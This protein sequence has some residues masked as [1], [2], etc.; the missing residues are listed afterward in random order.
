MAATLSAPANPLL[1]PLSLFLA[2]L[3]LSIGWG[4]RG[5]FGHESGAWIPG[6]LAA[7]AVYLLS[8]RDDWQRRV[9]YCALFGGLGWGFGGSISY[10]YT[11]AFAGSGQWQTTWYGYFAV[12]LVGG[13]W[14]G[15]GGAG[16]ALPLCID[17]DRLTRLFVPICFVLV[18]MIVNH[19][20]Y[21]PLS[22]FLKTT[23]AVAPDGTWG[24]HKSPL[25]WLDSDWLAA[26]WA[27]GG[28]CLYDL[29]ERRFSG[30]L[31]L[32]LLAAAGSI[33]GYLLQLALNLTGLSPHIA[34]VLVVPQGDLTAV[35]PETHEPFDPNNLLTN[36]PQFFSDFPEHLGWEIGLLVGVTIYFYRFGKWKNDAKL[37]LYMALGWLL[38]FL[39]MPVL[40]TIP[41]QHFGGFRLTPPRGD[42]WAGVLGV[43]IATC[44]YAMRY[45]MAPVA[46]AAV[47]NFVLGGISF[48]SMHFVRQMLMIP[49]HPALNWQSGGTPAAWQHFQNANWHSV[50]EQLQGFGFGIVTAITMGFLWP[51][52]QPTTD[53]PRVR[54]WTEVF[55]IDFVVCFMTWVNLVKNVEQWTGKEHPVVPAVMKA[56]LIAGIE[57]N[58]VVWFNLAWCAM[59]CAFVG[60]SIMHL[61]RRLEIVPASWIGR[62][63]LI[64]VLLLWIMVIGNFE[65]L[66][67]NFTEARLMTEWV[68][69]LNASLATFLAIVLPRPGTAVAI[70]EPVDYGPLI[71]RV[72]VIGLGSAAL[73]MTLFAGVIATVYGPVQDKI[74]GSQLRFGE[75]ATWRIK[76]ILKNKEHR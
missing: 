17:R 11:L 67:P 76:P 25:Y 5:Q 4:I 36:W 54:R 61:R 58:A 3:S 6:A 49:G 23:D 47:C 13:L 75:N 29:W 43:F 37:F 59:S 12:F 62:G 65:R 41:L 10:M 72:A 52:L 35:S 24:R 74:S 44:A 20:V 40:G 9:A 48:A 45:Q 14:A 32:V 51:R 60:L 57:L 19:F 63:Q 21:S 69:I 2:G 1:K 46:Y 71:R 73:L 18:A 7:I 64:Y 8:Q 34:N 33:A 22:D 39:I 70:D 42:D 15:L 31:H 55:S 27:L 56:P 30:W 50:L 26:L 38:A 28:V 68:I 16:T 53:E 66:L